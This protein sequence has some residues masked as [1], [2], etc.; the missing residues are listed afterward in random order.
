MGTN[1]CASQLSMMTY[2]TRRRLYDP[3][4]HV[5]LPMD[6]STIGLQIVTNKSARQ[7]GMTAHLR[8][9]AGD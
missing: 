1:T 3:K 9:Q 4:N 2:G 8:Y 7:M 6:H 5:L